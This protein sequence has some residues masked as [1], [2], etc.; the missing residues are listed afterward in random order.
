M[1]TY[2]L[3]FNTGW[4][5]DYFHLK[6]GG[7]ELVSIARM[8]TTPTGFGELLGTGSVFVSTIAIVGDLEQELHQLSMEHTKLSYSSV[9][10]FNVVLN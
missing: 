2:P 6:V 5:L 9:Q 3:M 7:C 8:Q 1:S 4:R 10:S